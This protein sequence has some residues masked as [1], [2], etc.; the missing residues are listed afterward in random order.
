ME[1]VRIAAAAVTL[2]LGAV[3][4]STETQLNIQAQGENA[5]GES[6]PLTNVQL[7]IIPYDIDALYEEMEAATQPGEPPAADSLRVLSQTYQDAC[8][9]YR[10][11]GDSIEA[12]RERATAI[13]DQTSDAYNAAFSEYQALVGREEERFARCQ[14]V[15]DTYTQVRNEYREGRQAWEERAW[16]EEQFTAAETE[17]IGDEIAELAAH[18]PTVAVETS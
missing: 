11:T 4:C 18:R 5:E 13:T 15:T 7:D 10:S 2:L 9:A 1:R 8:T 16:P 17:R 14:A 12:V 6:V 3:A